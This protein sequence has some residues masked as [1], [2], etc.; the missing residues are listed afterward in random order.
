MKTRN[1]IREHLFLDKVFSS[2]ALEGF[3]VFEVSNDKQ[4]VFAFVAL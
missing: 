3:V 2:S 4:P 1:R